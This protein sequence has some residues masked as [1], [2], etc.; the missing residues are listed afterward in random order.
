MPGD[1]FDS[2]WRLCWKVSFV[3]CWNVSSNAQ[4]DRHQ[5]LTK[6]NSK[7]FLRGSFSDNAAQLGRY[8]DFQS[9][10]RMAWRKQNIYPLKQARDKRLQRLLLDKHI[11]IFHSLVECTVKDWGMSRSF[12]GQ[13]HFHLPLFGGMY[14]QR[15]G[16]VSLL[17]T[18][19]LLFLM[20]KMDWLVQFFFL[21][22]IKLKSS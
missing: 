10:P 8:H 6:L 9:G 13:T 11:S 18:E 16:N 20:M 5:T 4:F 21:P 22:S 15:L 2:C 3:V 14:C 17:Y 1:S 19:R 7:T 12:A